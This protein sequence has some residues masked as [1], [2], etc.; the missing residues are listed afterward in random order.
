MCRSG[1]LDS[2][3]QRMEELGAKARRM[4][5][6]SEAGSSPRVRAAGWAGMLRV[7]WR[8]ASVQGVLG[9]LRVFC[10][11]SEIVGNLEG[12]SPKVR[13]SGW[14]S[15]LDTPPTRSEIRAKASQEAWVPHPHPQIVDRT[16]TTTD[17]SM[18]TRTDGK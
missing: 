7:L 16:D 18:R 15:L 17:E 13:A 12:V 1:E 2:M 10:E 9:V 5:E 11:G 3:A 14:T 4:E 6:L 8:N